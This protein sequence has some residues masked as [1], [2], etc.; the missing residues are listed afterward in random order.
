MSS[1][2]KR[3]LKNGSTRFRLKWRDASG[4]Q[5]SKTFRTKKDATEW[6]RKMRPETREMS[7]ATVGDY[8][9]L[10]LESGSARGWTESTEIRY[11][12]QVRSILNNKISLIPVQNLRPRDVQDFVFGLSS[13]GH[14]EKGV[15]ETHSRLHGVLKLAA[16]DGLIESLPTA[17]TTLPKKQSR[18]YPILDKEQVMALSE[19][20][21]ERYKIVVLLLAFTGIR[22][23]ELCALRARDI[24]T[25]S[26]ALDI[27][28]TIR[29]GHEGFFRASETKTRRS[30]RTVSVP[31]VLMPELRAR[32]AELDDDEELIFCTAAGRPWGSLGGDSWYHTA[33]KRLVKRG[34]IREKVSIH[35]LRHTAASLMISSGL[36]AAAVAR[37]LGHTTPATTM[38][39]YTSFFESRLGGIGQVLDDII[40]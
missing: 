8:C 25:D 15:R 33:V 24:H 13:D 20:V 31:Q 3:I 12:K 40:K 23:G 14:S 5:C 16:Q 21:P 29:Q 26:P 32:A 4:T 34:I 19:E 27:H 22:W 11:A 9:K 35:S 38:R 36:D 28:G 6:D 17:Y 1:I 39:V 18:H 30:Y 2:E 7:K 37:Q 10:F